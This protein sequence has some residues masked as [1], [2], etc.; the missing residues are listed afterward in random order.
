MK[1]LFTLT[2]VLFLV[3]L[4]GCR[5]NELI[6]DNSNNDA[7][8]NRIPE[9]PMSS[10][11]GDLPVDLIDLKANFKAKGDGITD[12]T[13]AFILASQY[14]NQNNDANHRIVLNIP[15][16]V[17]LVGW[18]LPPGQSIT[19]GTE[20]YTNSNLWT[21]MGINLID[22]KCCKNVTIQGDPIN[23]TAIQ[24]KAG[25]FFG[26]WHQNM[27]NIDNTA[28]P[29]NNRCDIGEC[30]ALYDCECITITDI[31]LNG[32]CFNYM[33]GGTYG[34]GYQL[35]SDGIFIESSND[36]YVERV[37]SI[38]FGRDGLFVHNKPFGTGCNEGAIPA[39][40][41]LRD[42]NFDYNCRQG[43]SLHSCNYL[44][45]TRCTFSHTGALHW[46]NLGAGLD[47]EPYAPGQQT[48]HDAYFTECRFENNYN[49]GFL[50][51]NADFDF[52]VDNFQFSNCVFWGKTSLSIWPAGMK[53]TKFSN[54]TIAGAFQQTV[55]G[56]QNDHMIFD[57]CT[58]LDHYQGAPSFP[59]FVGDYLMDMGTSDFYEF[60]NCNFEIRHQKLITMT[61]DSG[62]EPHQIFNNNYFR[63]F[64]DEMK[65][66]LPSV[67][68]GYIKNC[69]L[70]SNVF[71][72]MNP[73]AV[74]SGSAYYPIHIPVNSGSCSNLSDYQNRTEPYVGPYT[75][76]TRVYAC[77][78]AASVMGTF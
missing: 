51:D 70:I 71:E 59:G 2:A 35:E 31:T 58:I 29:S 42:C 62:N 47:V 75:Q 60:N 6:K 65:T 23:Y 72:D 50:C 46:N 8:S 28:W 14:I 12:D 45:A 44:T 10:C 48:C 55:G 11:N 39:N 64:T 4:I 30:I 76:V 43:L 66:T 40:I 7:I 13:R 36:V 22:L 57:N 26:G 54:C 17:Y 73:V 69:T 33:W 41:H 37:R 5:K 18:Q 3:G 74:A 63:F 24:Y 20:T 38:S 52:D 32:N 34:D 61:D 78:G 56:S 16:G 77:L 9:I 25:L 15:A 53:H 27:I 49:A 19:V 21:M 1:S 68:L 67:W